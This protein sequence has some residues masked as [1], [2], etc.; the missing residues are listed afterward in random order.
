MTGLRPIRS[1]SRDAG[2]IETSA[3][4]VAAASIC[5][6]AVSD[7]PLDDALA[8]AQVEDHEVDD[9]SRRP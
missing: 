6:T 5:R 3:A 8:A 4:S 9:G 2:M 1:D 7:V